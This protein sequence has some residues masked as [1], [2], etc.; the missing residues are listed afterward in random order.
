M[1]ALSSLDFYPMNPHLT[2]AILVPPQLDP[3]FGHVYEGLRTL[4]RYLG[5]DSFRK[6]F[7]QMLERN[8]R[9]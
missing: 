4:A 9:E 5:D 8:S 6:L 3:D 2:F 1:R 7:Q